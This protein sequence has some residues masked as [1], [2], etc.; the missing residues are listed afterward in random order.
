VKVLFDPVYTARPSVCSTSYLCWQIIERLLKHEE[1]FFVMLVPEQALEQE[2]QQQ[3]LMKYP[4]RVRLV[5]YPAVTTDRMREHWSFRDQFVDMA[6]PANKGLWDVDAIVSSRMNQLQMWRVNST[7]R[8]TYGKGSLRCV[9]GLEEMPQFS[10][11]DTV[12]WG[13]GGNMDLPSLASYWSS[14]A[15]VISSLWAKREVL[16]VAREYL[17]PSKARALEQQ[18]YEALPIRLE[19]FDLWEQAKIEAE[20]D[21]LNIAF[22]GRITGTRNFKDVAELFRKQFSFPLGKGNMK[23]VVSTNSESSGSSNY[24]DI[25]IIDFEYNDREKFYAFLKERAHVAVNLSTVEDFSLSTYEP[26]K[27]GVPM[28]VAD[29]PWSAFLGPTYPFRVKGEV[30]AYAWINEAVQDYSTFYG[31][32]RAWHDSY[33]REWVQSTQNVSTPE[34]VERLL[35]EHQ[36]NLSAYLAE[37]EMGATWRELIA[38]QKGKKLDLGKMLEDAEMMPPYGAPK[39]AVVTKTPT[40][41][42]V[43]QLAFLA[44]W[45]DTNEP[46]VVVR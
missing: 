31:R 29:R 17:A 40:F 36:G 41:Q 3:F 2:D 16:K 5:P 24:G 35:V 32:F 37:R 10:F 46:G 9:I 22:C 4:D 38:K 1:M 43:K 23:F 12:S 30:E 8:M 26:L 34:I 7:R 44:G 15:V 25:S 21:P 19:E 33:W 42:L 11:S 28:I 13:P 14:D 45:K 39:G 27:M 6:Q 20:K 18:I